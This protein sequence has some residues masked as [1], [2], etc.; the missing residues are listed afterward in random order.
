MPL[1]LA[2]VV[3]APDAVTCAM[4]S[5]LL[6]LVAAGVNMIV[7]VS[8]I[9]GSYDML[10]QEGEFSKKEKQAKTKLD[11]LSGVYWCLA[12]AIYLGWSFWTMRWDITWILWPV[13]GVLFA[14]VSGTV[15]LVI[16]ADGADQ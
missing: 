12:T 10:L 9:K 15:R 13:A 1:L 7:R 3:D 11:T 2:G 14:A 8:I 4:V 6:L 16:G 5:L